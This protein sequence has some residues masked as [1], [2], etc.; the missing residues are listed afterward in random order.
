VENLRKTKNEITQKLEE[1]RDNENKKRN[2]CEKN[3]FQ[4]VVKESLRNSV[5]TSKN[6][7]PRCVAFRCADVG[8]MRAKNNNS[9]TAKAGRQSLRN[10]PDRNSQ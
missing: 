10:I 4:L 3:D 2:A 5:T 7:P 1:S 6:K 8:G 9:L